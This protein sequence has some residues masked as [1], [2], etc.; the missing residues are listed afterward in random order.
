M[1]EHTQWYDSLILEETA[2]AL[3]KNGFETIAVDNTDSAR[4]KILDLIPKGAKTGL[5][6]SET[7]NQLGVIDELKRRGNKIIK[8]Q[9]Q[10]TLE[11][12]LN[13]WREAFSCDYYLA[14]P[15]AITTNGKMFFIDKYG[16]RLA[17]VIIG[18]KKVILVAGHNKIVEDD[19][20]ALWRIKN[21]AGV[22]N[23]HRLNC[24]T[25]CTKTGICSDCDSKD[26][27]CNVI[28]ILAKKPTTTDYL[29]ILVKE[30]LGY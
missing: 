2:V 9:P 30:I 15:Q 3:K 21:V 5:G 28:S 10:M 27:I 16:N 29:V 6:G 7:I 22:K 4:K 12:R 19:N 8:H 25:P 13:V 18:P 20:T 11:E 24:K 17:A 14:S 26:R 1:D 23:A